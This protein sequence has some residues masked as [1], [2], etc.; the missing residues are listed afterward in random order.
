M[1]PRQDDTIMDI[2]L[3]KTIG[4]YRLL[5]HDGNGGA[6]RNRC[7]TVLL[8]FTAVMVTVY[9]LQIVGMYTVIDDFP[10]LMYIFL[11]IAV[12]YT[13]AF[14]AYLLYRRA[15]LLR[16]ALELAGYGFTSSGRRDPSE[17]IRCRDTL[18]QV[19][20]VLASINYVTLAAWLVF[21]LFIQQSGLAADKPAVL[22]S[23]TVYN[24]W[25]PRA[26]KAHDSTL[27]YVAIYTFEMAACAYNV[28]VWTMFDCHMMTMCFVLNSNFRTMAADYR[29]LGHASKYTHIRRHVIRDR[30]GLV[31][32]LTRASLR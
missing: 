27:G 14:K 9:T 12:G 23:D 24:F 25:L 2:W 22:Y 26:E 16:S 4:L 3:F 18:S 15:D 21:P 30:C 8:V 29:T 5:W 17:M 19:L 7:R 20:R 32:V 6:Y 13:C 1:G 31:A 10:R 28:I 11:L